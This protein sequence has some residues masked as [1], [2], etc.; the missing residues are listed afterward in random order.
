[1]AAHNTPPFD[2]SGVDGYAVVAGPARFRDAEDR[3]RGIF[4]AMTWAGSGPRL[5]Q[6]LGG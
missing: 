6:L 5:G 2:R 1:M 4:S 3:A